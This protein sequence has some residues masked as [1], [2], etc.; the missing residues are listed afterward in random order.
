MCFGRR[1][2][3]R[4]VLSEGVRLAYGSGKRAQV[5][6]P[7]PRSPNGLRRAPPPNSKV[8]EWLSAL[9][10]RERLVPKADDGL[11]PQRTHGAH[12]VRMAQ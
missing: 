6:T 10:I 8:A 1:S 3:A 4:R 5:S 12:D 11:I 2:Y 9:T 7:R